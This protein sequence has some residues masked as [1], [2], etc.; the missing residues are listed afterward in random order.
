ML[1]DTSGAIGIFVEKIDDLTLGF[2]YLNDSVFIPG[3][4]ITTTE[5]EI[6]GVLL[7]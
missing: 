5:T 7:S 1:S 3:E 4:E 6:E 2:C